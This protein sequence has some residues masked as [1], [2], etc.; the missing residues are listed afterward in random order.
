MKAVRIHEYGGPG[1]MVYEDA[2]MP[3]ITLDEVLIKIHAA[4]V[5]PVDWKTREGFLKGVRTYNFPLILGWDVAGVIEETGSGV[6]GFKKGDEVYARPDIT[7]N[8]SYAE[9]IAV[10]AN[11]VAFKPKNIDFCTA[12]A[13]PLA[14]LTAWQALFD[15]G[16]LKS[17]Q[18]VLILGASGGVGSFAVQFAKWKKANVIGVASA[19][20]QEL[21]MELGADYAINYQTTA[22]QTEVSD[23]DL[24][25]DTVGENVREHAW[26]VMKNGGMLVSITGKPDDG[27]PEAK[28][29]TGIAVRVVPNSVQLTEIGTLIEKG[30]VKPIVSKIFPLQEVAKALNMLQNGQN[31][32]GKIVLKVAD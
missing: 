14:G 5:N 9:Y 13:V 25:F 31:Q 11:E 18:K 22:Y 28:G 3:V 7:R 15:A 30:I 2:P 32:Y 27:V 23:A 26:N 16:R 19:K 1:V 12:A 10:K 29:K 21:I 20:N 8:G 17:G 6:K 24:V 4:A